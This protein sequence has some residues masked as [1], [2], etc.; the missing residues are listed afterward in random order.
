MSIYKI[1]GL[2]FLNEDILAFSTQ[3]KSPAAN[4][5]FSLGKEISLKKVVKIHLHTCITCTL[6]NKAVFESI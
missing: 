1:L 4:S 2:D 3:K 5:T 6:Y